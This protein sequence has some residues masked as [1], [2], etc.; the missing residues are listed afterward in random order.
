VENSFLQRKKNKEEE[1]EDDDD[2][3]DDDDDDD[4]GEDHL[5]EILQLSR[6]RLC[7][8]H[9]PLAPFLIFSMLPMHIMPLLFFT[10]PSS[11]SSSSSSSHTHTHRKPY[12]S[13]QKTNPMSSFFLL[14]TRTTLSSSS[15]IQTLDTSSPWHQ[16]PQQTLKPL[17]SSQTAKP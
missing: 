5:G 4:D 17:C 11:S 13:T 16:T 3:D 14:H 8:A 7:W 2:G 6:M 9:V 1:E 12:S 15:G 10:S